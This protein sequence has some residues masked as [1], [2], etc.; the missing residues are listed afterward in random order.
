MPTSM[1]EMYPGVPGTGG[2]ALPGRLDRCAGCRATDVPL[3]A[4]DDLDGKGAVT[5]PSKRERYGNF[6]CIYLLIKRVPALHVHVRVHVRV[7][8]CNT[9]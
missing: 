3:L 4:C 9:S 2:G 8:S 6:G 7:V 1:E 5:D